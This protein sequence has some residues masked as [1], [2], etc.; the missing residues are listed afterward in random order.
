M[1]EDYKTRIMHSMRKFHERNDPTFQK[2][3]EKKERKKSDIPSEHWEQMQVVNWMRKNGWI[4]F[5]VPNGGKRDKIAGAHLRAEGVQSGVPDLIM[6]APVQCVIEMK[7][8][9]GGRVS[10]SQKEWLYKFHDTG[11]WKCKVA[12]GH[13]EA[14]EFLKEVQNVDRED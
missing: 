3:K 4:Y 6:I 2:P 12:H 14:I 10:E 13:E 8:T 11:N 7:R 5:A 9:K 1:S